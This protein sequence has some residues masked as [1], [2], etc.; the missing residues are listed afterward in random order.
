M[1]RYSRLLV[2]VFFGAYFWHYVATYR[3]WHFIDD[4][5]LI[6]HEAGHS[7]FQFFGM[8]VHIAAGSGF[9]ILLPLFFSW[10][11]FRT[12]QNLS[13]AVCLMWLGQNLLN[14]SI[15]AGDATLMQLPLL[16]GDGVI[17]DW[18]YILSAMGILQYTDNVAAVFYFFGVAIIFI[19]S[20]L[21][22]YFAL[23]W[24]EHDPN[25]PLYE[26]YRRAQIARESHQ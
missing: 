24:E 20:V 5:N 11:F 21:A 3:E 16:G 6:F 4:V 26:Q 23:Y 13:G 7:I 10:Y 25:F 9:Q 1:Q 15:Y 12:K 14:V 8:F 19:G 18:N 22:I 2:A 17:H